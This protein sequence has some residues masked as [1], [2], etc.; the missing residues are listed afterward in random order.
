MGYSEL[1]IN[2]D[3]SKRLYAGFL[4]KRAG[5]MTDHALDI[6]GLSIEE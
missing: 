6:V 5:D 4:L 2:H 3:S 1:C